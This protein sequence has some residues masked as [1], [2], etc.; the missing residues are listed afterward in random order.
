M[1][2]A[3]PRALM[4]LAG[5]RLSSAESG[6]V[7]LEA[8]LAVTGAHDAVALCF[9]PSSKFA[10]AK[11]GDSLV[12]ALGEEGSEEDVWSGEVSAARAEP[13]GIW[14][15]GLAKTSALSRARR[16]QTYLSQSIA[17]IVRDLASDVDQDQVSEDLELEA[18]SVDDR[19]SVWA[20][21]L[22]LAELCGAEVGASASGGLRFVPIESG[23]ADLE[24]RYGA[25]VLGWSLGPV[26]EQEPPQVEA[27]GSASDAGAER[28]YWL[29]RSPVGSGSAAGATRVV[30][31]FRTRAAADRLARAL[32]DRAARAAVKGRL[33]LVGRADLR[34]GQ[35][36]AVKGLPSG[37]PGTLRAL[38]V[39]HCF[40]G[41]V[42]F[43]TTV[44]VE[45]AG[46]GGG[47]L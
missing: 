6:L 9:W 18:Y 3:R 20:H 35:R 11:T 21:V 27:S 23:S 39:E 24:L 10:G 26:R 17:D 16:S 34:P 22:E 7:R 41:S 4:T 38:S 5:Q 31:A 15:E 30:P 45:G 43:T 32:S 33:S 36:V 40:D 28:W 12:V 37:D 2:L 42:G 46:G 29:R 44:L 25:D 19:R 13:D 1:T 8:S 14:I 47:L